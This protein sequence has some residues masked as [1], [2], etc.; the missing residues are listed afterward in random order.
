M[1]SDD[2]NEGGPGECAGHEFAV[3]EVTVGDPVGAYV[4]EACTR[5]GSVVLVGPDELGGWV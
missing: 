3:V 2:R 5:C 1:G 4:E